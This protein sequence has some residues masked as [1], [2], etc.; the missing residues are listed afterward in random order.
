MVISNP[1]PVTGWFQ[2]SDSEPQ[3]LPPDDGGISETASQGESED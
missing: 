3:F 2:A 1:V